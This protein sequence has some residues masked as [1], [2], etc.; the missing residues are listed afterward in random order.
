MRINWIASFFTISLIVSLQAIAQQPTINVVTTA[1]PFLRIGP[2]AR[3]GGMG[4]N[5]ITT[6][7]DAYNMF[8]NLA[9]TPFA[10]NQGAFGLSYSP[11]LRDIGVSDVYLI[12]ASGYYKLDEESAISGGFRFFNLGDIQFTD[13][14]GNN[15]GTG[16]PTELGVDIGYSRKLSDRW[17]IGAALRYI[18]SNLARGLPS[19]SGVDYRAGNTLA[20]DLS[21]YYDGTNEIGQGLRAGLALTNLGGKVSYTNIETEKEYIP[22][23]FGIGVGYNFVFEEQHRL[24][25]ALDINKLMVPTPPVPTGVDSIDDANLSKYRSYGVVESWIVSWGDAP[26]GFSEELKEFTFSLGAEYSYQ[27]QFFVRAGYYY[28]NP[29]KG[30]RKYA[31]AG[32]GIRLWDKAMLDFSYLI[33]SGSGTNRNPLSNTLRFG[34]T[35]D[36]PYAQ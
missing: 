17:G 25:F 26:G 21:F 31:T 20:G 15:L 10:Q 6:G 18:N 24:M 4:D 29:T 30:N 28:E 22:A 14:S 19:Q 7:P 33:P 5:A 8:W 32:L 16:K 11:W 27:N 1:V 23:N 3:A 12:G 34:L 36:F 35:F 9:K 2:D 13:A